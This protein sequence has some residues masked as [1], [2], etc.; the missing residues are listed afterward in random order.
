MGQSGQRCDFAKL[1]IV[2]AIRDHG[3]TVSFELADFGVHRGVFA[4]SVLI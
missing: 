3:I 1:V 4:A 2:A